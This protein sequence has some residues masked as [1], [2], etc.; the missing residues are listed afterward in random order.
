MAK[1]GAVIGIMGGLV[2]AYLNYLWTLVAV[3]AH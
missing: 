2:V 3:H 1:T